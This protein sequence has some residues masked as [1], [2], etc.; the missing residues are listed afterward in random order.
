MKLAKISHHILEDRV[1]RRRNNFRINGI[2]E[3]NSKTWEDVEVQVEQAINGRSWT[4]KL[5]WK[6]LNGWK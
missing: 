5:T 1:Q 6:E 4:Q 3:Y 2:P